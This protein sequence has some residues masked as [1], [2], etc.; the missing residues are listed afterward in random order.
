MAKDSSAGGFS[1]AGVSE[2]TAAGFEMSSGETRNS[3]AQ[4]S[5]VGAWNWMTGGLSAGGFSNIGISFSAVG[6]QISSEEMR[7]SEAGDSGIGT[8]WN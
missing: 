4:N 5:C 3:D 7:N 1:N 8:S 2:P 6:F